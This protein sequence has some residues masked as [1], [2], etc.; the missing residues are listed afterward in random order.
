VS[1]RI[2]VSIKPFLQDYTKMLQLTFPESVQ[3]VYLIGSAAL[4]AFN[5]QR[6][7]IDCLVLLSETFSSRELRKLKRMH[8]RLIDFNTMAH[9]LDVCYC[10]GKAMVDGNSRCPVFVN[11]KWKS[12]QAITQIALV[13]LKT[14]GISLLGLDKRAELPDADCQRLRLEMAWNLNQY[15]GRRATL[16]P[17]RFWLD[18]PCE[19]AVLTLCRILYTLEMHKVISKRDAAR[20]GLEKLPEEWHPLIREALRI[21]YCSNAKSPFD[22]RWQRLLAVRRFISEIQEDCGQKYFQ[23]SHTSTE[24]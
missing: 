10:T 3:A 9:R 4:E 21:R 17:W 13:E 20:Y 24:N 7:D 5:D 16:E 19:T 11:G 2:P 8:R 6:S 18:E 12:H 1:E 22:S 15:W 23:S 14:D